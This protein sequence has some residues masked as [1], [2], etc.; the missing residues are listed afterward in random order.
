MNPLKHARIEF[1]GSQE[2]SNDARPGSRD[3][4]N[5]YGADAARNAYGVRNKKVDL[6]KTRKQIVADIW[7]RW[8]RSCMRV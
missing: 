6:M 4:F 5:H 1:I 8:E 7:R 3:V 2:Y